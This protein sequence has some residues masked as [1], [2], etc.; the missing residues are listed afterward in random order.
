MLGQ[1]NT[2]KNSYRPWGRKEGDQE[3]MQKKNL[4]Q[5]KMLTA[6]EYCPTLRPDF[7]IQE[8]IKRRV[9]IEDER[10]HLNMPSYMPPVPKIA[11][12][13]KQRLSW[14]QIKFGMRMLLP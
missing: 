3:N 1:R 4:Q 5:S 8:A 13:P 7:T 6:M 11:P 2:P 14:A 9:Q 10:N 12:G